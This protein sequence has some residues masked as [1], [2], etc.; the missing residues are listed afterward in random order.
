MNLCSWYMSLKQ[1]T[2]QLPLYKR[3]AKGIQIVTERYMVPE[4]IY[5]NISPVSFFITTIIEKAP[6]GFAC[7][8][9]APSAPKEK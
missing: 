2:A 3:H 9:T 7:Y 4:I 6:S 5:G 1:S 8:M